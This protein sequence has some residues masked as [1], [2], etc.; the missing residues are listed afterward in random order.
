MATALTLTKLLVVISERADNTEINTAIGMYVIYY[1]CYFVY[2]GM[3][4]L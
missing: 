2:A 1:S 3:G 4:L